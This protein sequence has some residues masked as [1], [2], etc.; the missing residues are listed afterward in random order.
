MAIAAPHV[1]VAIPVCNEVERI[2]ACL[3]AL[4]RQTGA[5]AGK[6]VLLLNNCD[7]GTA[8]CVRRIEPALA[9]ECEIIERELEGEQ[10]S[11]GY[12]RSLA[13]RYAAI[14]LVDHDLLVTTDADG[15]VAENWIAANLAAFACGADAVCG[16]AEIDP[17]E[18]RLISAHLHEDDARECRLGAL[19]DEIAAL[20]DPDPH[21]PWPRHTE[22]SGASIAVTV[23]A[24]RRAGG[25]PAMPSGEDRAFI[26]RLRGIVTTR[27]PALWE[28]IRGMA[29]SGRDD[30][31]MKAL[32]A[33]DGS[34]RERTAF[35]RAG[36][37]DSSR[38]WVKA[39]GTPYTLAQRVWRQGRDTRRQIDATIRASIRRGDDVATLTKELRR[40]LN[41]DVQ[42]AA[43]AAHRLAQTEVMHAHGIA[44]VQAGKVVPGATGMKWTLHPEHSNGNPDECDDKARNHSEGMEPGCYTF[45]EFPSFPTHP[46]DKCRTQ[47]IFLGERDTMDLVVARYGG[48]A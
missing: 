10:A 34:F 8:A 31:F 29:I 3:Q 44:M 25:M 7:D 23:S 1:V 37:L 47:V 17:V 45:A 15:E 30:P 2:E 21:D 4:D 14:G 12:A 48:A 39:D 28:R 27:D 5:Q 13:L 43:Y 41:P 42:N 9:I 16:R 26:D 35:L 32:R 11:A 24:W 33:M 36:K 18:A 22:H 46:F 19:N 20:L 6:V 40:F 38:R